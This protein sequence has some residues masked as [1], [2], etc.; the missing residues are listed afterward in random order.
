M[1]SGPVAAADYGFTRIA[2]DSGAFAS[3]GA[4]PAPSI[5]PDGTVAFIAPLDSGETSVDQG[6][7]GATTEVVR[8]AVGGLQTITGPPAQDGAGSV[9]FLAETAAGGAAI[10]KGSIG[11]SLLYGG[12]GLSQH[13]VPRANDGGTV[14]FRAFSATPTS[15]DKI[16][17]GNGGPVTEVAS[18]P[19][20]TTAGL[21]PRYGERV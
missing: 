1:A 6:D 9:Y 5:A 16:F 14:A 7:G 17:K 3:F 2:D 4:A 18:V 8:T 21:D 20:G 15:G 12:A 13:T 11:A 19:V 10:F